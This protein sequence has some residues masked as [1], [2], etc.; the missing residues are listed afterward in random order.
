MPTVQRWPRARPQGLP[1]RTDL[2]AATKELVDDVGA[3]TTLPLELRG[4]LAAEGFA[5][6]DVA[7]VAVQH[8]RDG[9]DHQGVVPA[10]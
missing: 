9:S 5:L 8:S 1:A 6:D 2:R 4:E 3:I 7:P 10:A